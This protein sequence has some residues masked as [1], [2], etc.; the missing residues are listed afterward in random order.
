M[1]IHTVLGYGSQCFTFTPNFSRE[2]DVLFNSDVILGCF[3][4][5][6]YTDKLCRLLG[7]SCLGNPKKVSPKHV[8]PELLQISAL[9]RAWSSTAADSD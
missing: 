4:F 5:A 2:D 3:L 9:V 8:A 6:M 7:K 1:H